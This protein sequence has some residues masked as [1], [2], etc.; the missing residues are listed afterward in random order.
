MPAFSVPVV[1]DPE[2]FYARPPQFVANVGAD[3]NRS[4]GRCN[5]KFAGGADGCRR[6]PG[7]SVQ[8]SEFGVTGSARRLKIRQH[9]TGARV[10]GPR[11][12]E[13]FHFVLGRG[14]RRQ[15]G[16]PGTGILPFRRDRP[17]VG[18]VTITPRSSS[19]NVPRSKRSKRTY[20][21][22]S[23][24]DAPGHF[25]LFDLIRSI[26]SGMLRTERSLLTSSRQDDRR[27]GCD[28]GADPPTRLESLVDQQR[29]Q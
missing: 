11:E 18:R 26:N 29:R 24:P 27:R 8:F 3:R 16:P 1:P 21:A 19:A 13:P 6:N 23:G 2:N 7:H 5:A 10:K 17:A 15:D 22:G 9:S 14:R 12:S 25:A 4:D 20:R 28:A